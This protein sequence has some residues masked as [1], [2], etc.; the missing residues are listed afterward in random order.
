MLWTLFCQLG[1]LTKKLWGFFHYRPVEE[2]VIIKGE[3]VARLKMS[4]VEHLRLI[5]G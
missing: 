2:Y 1:L 4:A 3:L 5:A